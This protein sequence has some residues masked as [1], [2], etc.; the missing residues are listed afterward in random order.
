MSQ[1][2]LWKFLIAVSSGGLTNTILLCGDVQWCFLWLWQFFKNNILGWW[3]GHSL[4]ATAMVFHLI[5]EFRWLCFAVLMMLERIGMV[6]FW[7][8][9]SDCGDFGRPWHAFPDFGRHLQ[10]LTDFSRLSPP[11]PDS[12]RLSQTLAH[13]IMLRRTLANFDR[14]SQTLADLGRPWQILAGFDRLWKALADFGRLSVAWC[15][16][17]FDH[18][19]LIMLGIDGDCFHSSAIVPLELW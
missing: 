10:T 8:T 5:K 1:L 14:F 11:L 12:H 7:K 9:S 4:V 19:F 3:F 18:L 15:G 2:D 6:Y 17:K 16:G 13:F